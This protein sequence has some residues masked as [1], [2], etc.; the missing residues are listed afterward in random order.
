MNFK[1]TAAIT[2]IGLMCATA[3]LIT[4]VEK[5]DAATCGTY[6]H[7]TGAR[8]YAY[9]RG[10]WC[11][12]GNEGTELA[13]QSDGNMVVSQYGHAFWATGTNRRGT[14]LRF[15]RDGNV[16]IYQNSSAVW[17]SR[18]AGHSQ[19]SSNVYY[20]RVTLAAG[21]YGTGKTFPMAWITLNG[22]TIWKS[23]C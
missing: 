13:F 22:R 19:T 17:S 21:C 15:Q 1:R 9:G 18:T 2:A 20:M 3:P 5:A 8:G 23:P 11:I 16:V 4:S 10:G 12:K 6:G 7:W 14:Q